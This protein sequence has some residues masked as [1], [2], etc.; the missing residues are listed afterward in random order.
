MN[1][2][3]LF[4]YVTLAL[5]LAVLTNG[6][7]QAM[8]LEDQPDETILH[9]ASFLPPKDALALGLAS[10]RYQRITSDNQL[11]LHYYKR[12]VGKSKI[13]PYLEEGVKDWK[14]FYAFLHKYEKTSLFVTFDKDRPG[15]LGAM[16]TLQ[17]VLR[18]SHGLVREGSAL[19]QRIKRTQN[20]YQNF[21]RFAVKGKNLEKDFIGFDKKEREKTGLESDPS[22]T[23]SRIPSSLDLEKRYK[24]LLSWAKEGNERGQNL[25]RT[26]ISL[27]ADLFDFI[28]EEDLYQDLRDCSGL[29]SRWEK[30]PVHYRMMLDP[31][32]VADI[33]YVAHLLK[34]DVIPEMH[35]RLNQ[36]KESSHRLFRNLYALALFKGEL[37]AEEDIPPLTRQM[38]LRQRSME[39]DKEAARYNVKWYWRT[40]IPQEEKINLLE[41]DYY[42][43]S[44][45]ASIHN[46]SVDGSAIV[47][48][49]RS[50]HLY[51]PAL[52]L[53]SYLLSKP[54]LHCDSAWE[55]FK[56]ANKSVEEQNWEKERDSSALFFNSLSFNS[57]FFNPMYRE[58]FIKE[59]DLP[60]P[61][62]D[63]HS[64]QRLYSYLPNIEE[65]K[66]I[67]LYSLL[68]N[69]VYNVI[70]GNS[71]LYEK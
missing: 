55:P 6:Q 39:G 15:P 5:L 46:S 7:T 42:I 54:L 13:E 59:D 65:L 44:L 34:I 2:Y 71:Q 45:A 36:L 19:S 47:N 35:E 33:S 22:L 28:S 12:K 37:G 25:F 63:V 62:N 32:D 38:E 69:L 52:A 18:E 58:K 43:I 68:I 49:Y 64:L 31:H 26:F 50:R 14:G 8:T 9:I 51:D 61:Q 16:I 70:F 10:K 27:H 48:F 4:K 1:F 60:P 56:K 11:W 41:I 17:W 30:T 20:F 3:S 24:F 57:H 29:S 23:L 21:T 40:V 66:A 53:R 67:I